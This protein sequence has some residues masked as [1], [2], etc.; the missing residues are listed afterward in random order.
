MFLFPDLI[1]VVKDQL[2]GAD[3]VK[4]EDPKVYQSEKSGRGPLTENWLDEYWSEVSFYIHGSPYNARSIIFSVFII[5]MCFV[6]LGHLHKFYFYT[7]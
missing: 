2:H 1:D 3:Y 5:E 4:E 6:V 7:F